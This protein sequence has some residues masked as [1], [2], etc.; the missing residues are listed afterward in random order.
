MTEECEATASEV[1]N[2]LRSQWDKTLLVLH[3]DN[4]GE[5][6]TQFCGSSNHP[7]RGGKFSNYE[8]G[9]RVNALVSGGFLPRERRG[10][11]LES[12]FGGEDWLKTYSAIAGVESDWESDVVAVNSGL[13]DFDGVNQW[14]VILGELEFAREEI[15]IG[16]TS[17]IEFNG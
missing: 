12:L 7:L 10:T 5:I 4:G 6:M 15:A 3:S 13:P 1:S 2:S 11:K 14:P 17:A 9:I 16:D 8:G